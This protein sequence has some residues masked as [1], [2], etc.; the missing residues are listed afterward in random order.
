MVD[1]EVVHQE[2]PPPHRPHV[3]S[4]PFRGVMPFK[5]TLASGSTITVKHSL[6]VRPGEAP[7]FDFA[8]YILYNSGGSE[9]GRDCLVPFGEEA[10]GGGE[11]DLNGDGE[12]DFVDYDEDGNIWGFVCA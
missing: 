5:T 12:N 6:A 8:S 4:A 2:C 11:L 3:A 7:A 10:L 1:G 9:A